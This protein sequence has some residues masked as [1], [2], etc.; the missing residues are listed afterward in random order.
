MTEQAEQFEGWKARIGGILKWSLRSLSVFILVYLAVMLVGGQLYRSITGDEVPEWVQAFASLLQSSAQLLV[1]LVAPLVAFQSKH[2]PK[3]GALLGL[4]ASACLLS[5]TLLANN[6]MALTRPRI[7]VS[8]DDLVYRGS[9]TWRGLDA[10]R[11]AL[12]RRGCAPYT[13]GAAD[14][15]KPECFKRLV[16]ASGG[17]WIDTAYLMNDSLRAAGVDHVHAEILCGSACAMVILA[18]AP[19][20][21]VANGTALMFHSA[22]NTSKVAQRFRG[23]VDAKIANP[24]LVRTLTDA[25]MTRAAALG[26]VTSKDECYLNTDQLWASG[27]RL[28]GSTG[29]TLNAAKGCSLKQLAG[30]GA[31]GRRGP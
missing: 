29:V 30:I 8:G 28:E 24:R 25:G 15:A 5:L 2:G 16:I 19:H 12:L 26:V 13:D 23:E 20:R 11:E 9:I 1:F 18:G 21:S 10:V 4:S 27:F 3:L 31:V 22:G 6:D 7:E 17:G 14:E